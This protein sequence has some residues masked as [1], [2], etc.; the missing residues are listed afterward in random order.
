VTT[1]RG[2]RRSESGT[3]SDLARA[4]YASYVERMK[5]TEPAP[6]RE[7]YCSLIDAGHQVW[8]A[9]QDGNVV[10]IL[11]LK[12]KSDHLL[13]DNVAVTPTAQG[14]GV[15]AQLLKFAEARAR[16]QDLRE[17]RLYTNQAM[18]ENVAYYAHHGFVETHRATD[19]GYH[20]VYFTKHL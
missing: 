2:A 6:M 18:T 8:V 15:G 11:V 7:D 1:I 19:H 10:G 17:I 20:R 4:A 9:E 3:L 12:T 5:G 14:T 13:L 16:E